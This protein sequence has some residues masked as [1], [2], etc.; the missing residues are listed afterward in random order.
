M[1]VSPGVVLPLD[2]G[3]APANAVWPF[4]GTQD[5]LE[6]GSVVRVDSGTMLS[7][8]VDDDGT[9]YFLRPVTPLAEGLYRIDLVTN[10]RDGP[11]RSQEIEVTSEA[12]LPTRL[13][14]L[15][16]GPPHAAAIGLDFGSTCT[17]E[18]LGVGSDVTLDLDLDASPW[19]DVL[20]F[21]TIVDGA[22]YRPRHFSA[23][24]PDPDT[25]A[26]AG[27]SWRGRARDLVYTAC[28][29]DPSSRLTGGPVSEGV[30]VVKMQARLAG[31]DVVLETNEV[32]VELRCA[33]HDLTELRSRL[34][35]D[36][37]SAA[38]TSSPIALIALVFAVLVLRRRA[39]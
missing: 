14:V 2:G 36:G 32:T 21:T 38:G 33:A 13:G 16:A 28:V 30:H 24:Q 9:L 29:S 6:S 19:A 17:T 15:R 10:C 26:Y 1:C 35:D 27:G 23:P 5:G 11:R 7:A 8:S 39:G 37:C 3:A 22:P 12:P 34:N 31:T 4:I 20:V 25:G 18:T